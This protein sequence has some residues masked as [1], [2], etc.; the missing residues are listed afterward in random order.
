VAQTSCRKTKLKQNISVVVVVV[1]I[2]IIIII[3]GVSGA[4]HSV[5]DNC[6]VMGPAEL[7]T[8][9]NKMLPQY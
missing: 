9:I 5:E 3:W 7:I 6:S 1:V 4:K 8:D 2:I